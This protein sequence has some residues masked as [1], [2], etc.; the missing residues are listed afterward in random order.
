MRT[1]A[2][3]KCKPAPLQGR[4]II[5][6]G[7]AD[8]SSC[9]CFDLV[10]RISVIRHAG[11]FPG[12]AWFGPKVPLTMQHHHHSHL[13]LQ[14][15]RRRNKCWSGRTS[16]RDLLDRFSKLTRF[17]W[18]LPAKTPVAL[19]KGSFCTILQT[20]G[21]TG[22]W[23]C[24]S[25]GFGVRLRL[26]CPWNRSKSAIRFPSQSRGLIHFDLE[27]GAWIAHLQL[28]FCLFAAPSLIFHEEGLQVLTPFLLRCVVIPPQL[29]VALTIQSHSEWHRFAEVV[30]QHTLFAADPSSLSQLSSTAPL[31]N[32]LAVMLCCLLHSQIHY[33]SSNTRSQLSCSAP[34]PDTFL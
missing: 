12:V 8:T 32:F 30:H 20:T 29:C 33:F 1:W 5:L 11:T 22:P 15:L 2:A 25:R 26:I 18:V 7:S 34:L 10:D 24:P 27:S 19:S 21:V 28:K 14:K 17:G 9:L 16:D 4:E 31:R 3:T 13:V 23:K 6:G